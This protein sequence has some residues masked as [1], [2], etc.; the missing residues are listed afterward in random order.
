MTEALRILGKASSINVR[1][2]LWTCR[3]VGRDFVREDWGS[4][5]QPVDND[6]F[7]RINPNA[8]VPVIVVPGGYL[9]ESNSICRYLAADAGRVD[10]LPADPLARAKVEMWMD[11]QATELNPAWRYAFMSL[12][13]KSERFGDP[14]QVAASITQWNHLTAILDAQLARTGAYVAGADFTLADIVLG[15][16]VNRWKMTPMER[17][18]LPALEGWWDRLLDRPG[19]QEFGA[20]GIP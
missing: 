12:V 5:F 7:R 6:E 8:Q 17:P 19:F 20:N 13:R 1:K 18:H 4:G 11:W 14:A 16:S 15:L 3:E 9:W 10:L 2:V